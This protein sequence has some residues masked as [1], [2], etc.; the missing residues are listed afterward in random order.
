MPGVAAMPRRDVRAGAP[1][2]GPRAMLCKDMMKRPVE[3]I[4]PHESVQTAAQRMRDAN[5]GLLPVCDARGQLVGVITDRDIVVRL[6]ADGGS[7]TDTAIERVMSPQVIRC[8]SNDDVHVAEDLMMRERKSRIVVT[9]DRDRPAGVISLSDVAGQ[10]PAEAARVLRH[11]AARE[12]LG[13]K[14]T[15]PG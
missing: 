6:C 13:P 8:S 7:P 9:D 11:V 1:D 15:R 12:V 14:G 5:I 2:A 10:A 3:T 4:Q